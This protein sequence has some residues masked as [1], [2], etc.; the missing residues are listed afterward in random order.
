LSE[1]IDGLKRDYKIEETA[2][3]QSV[4]AQESKKPEEK[5]GNVSIKLVEI[6][7]GSSKVLIYKEIVSIVKEHKE[8][9]ISPI[10]AKK[11][12]E[13]EDKIILKDVPRDKV[14]GEKGIKKRLEDLGAT[15]EIK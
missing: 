1:L 8:E 2:V 14:E 10:L 12:V 4:V 11:L 6:K 3:V 13:R 7:E 15:V 9:V 5:G